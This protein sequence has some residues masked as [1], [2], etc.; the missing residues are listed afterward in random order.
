MTRT[1]RTQHLWISGPDPMLHKMYIA[2]GYHRVSARLRGDGWDMTWDEW[3]DLWLPVWSQRGRTSSE[4]C[5]ARTDIEKPW[6]VNNVEIITR[7]EH[8]QRTRSYYQ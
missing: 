5:M 1:R 3:R 4:L 7:R 2:F 6:H 8:G